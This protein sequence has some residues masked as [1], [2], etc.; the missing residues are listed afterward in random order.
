MTGTNAFAEDKSLTENKSLSENQ[1]LPDS[2][3]TDD[4]VYEYTFSDFDKAQRIMK[5]LRKRKSLPDYRLDVTEG[6]LYYNRGYFHRALKYYKRALDNDSVRLNDERYMD[7][8]HRMI[9]LYDYLHNDVAKAQYV[10]MLLKKAEQCGNAPMKAVALFNMGRMLYFQGNKNRGYELMKQGAAQMEQTDYRLKYDNLRYHYNTLFMFQLKDQQ[11]EEALA[12]L[13]AL[14]KVVTSETGEETQIEGLADKEKKTM[15]AQYATVLLQLGRTAEAD[16]YYRRFLA[17]AKEN[18]YDNYLIMTYLLD[19]GMYDE[20]ISLNTAREKQLAAH[21]DTVTYHM[22]TVK[23]FLGR[24]YEEKGNYRAAARY[25]KELAVLRDSIKNREQESTALELAA[26]YETHEKDLIIKQQKSDVQIRTFWL[27]LAV[28]A[29]VL[30]GILLC[31]GIRYYRKIQ[32]KNNALVKNI[33]ELLHYKDEIYQAKDANLAL[34]QQVIQLNDALETLQAKQ[35]ELLRGDIEVKV[36]EITAET[37]S[38]AMVDRVATVEMA[39]KVDKAVT[40]ETARREADATGTNI[41]AETE[42]YLETA[43]C[44]DTIDGENEKENAELE[45]EDCMDAEL[46]AEAGDERYGKELYEQ[47]EHLIISGQLYLDPSFSGEKARKLV[48]IPRNRFVPFIKLYTGD[49]FLKYLNRL[50]IY[51]AARLLQENPDYGIE[52][53][54][55]ESGIPALRSFHRLFLEEFGVTPTEYRKKSKLS[56]N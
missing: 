53:V 17:L 11:F 5:E 6:D 35:E 34:K 37:A 43:V 32:F 30:L 40:E 45:R 20:L 18:D 29:T 8:I 42:E 13:E 39:V 49:R 22:T 50:R 25:Y 44:D 21:G 9:S 27:V 15:Y 24:A 1:S 54:A 31:L 3:I 7:Q 52:T 51:H 47:L 4:C 2:L 28:C 46:G 26:L 56:D 38:T 36:N 16:D 41:N 33:N 14:K 48:G 19:R 23:K 12:S 55:R 10:D